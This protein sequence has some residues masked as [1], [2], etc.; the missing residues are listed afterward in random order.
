MKKKAKAPRWKKVA[1]PY[2][3][4]VGLLAS[5]AWMLVLLQP[6]WPWMN[7]VRLRL[8]KK[9]IPPLSHSHLAGAFFLVFFKKHSRCADGNTKRLSSLSSGGSLFPVFFKKTLPPPFRGVPLSLSIYIGERVGFLSP[10]LIPPP[11]LPL[12]QSLRDCWE[13]ERGEGAAL[14]ETQK[15]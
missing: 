10:H 15:D 3:A 1:T 2:K 11:P 13:W 7:K 5:E 6:P 9:N 8:L 12:H 4:G 14:T